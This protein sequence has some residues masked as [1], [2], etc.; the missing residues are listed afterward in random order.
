MKKSERMTW[1]DALAQGRQL[2][3]ML[4]RAL[5]SVT[6]GET[7][8]TP[9]EEEVTEAYFFDETTAIHA[10]RDGD[11]LCAVR[12][13]SEEGDRYVEECRE[14]E[15]SALGKYLTVRKYLNTDED[16]QCCVERTLPVRWEGGKADG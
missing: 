2:R 3:W 5:S 1:Q 7:G 14:V 4:V 12:W 15:N 10:F 8:E 6:L 11:R 13:T 9:P 16:G